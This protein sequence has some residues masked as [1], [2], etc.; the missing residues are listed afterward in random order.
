MY[1]YIYIYTKVIY[2]YIY[3][4]INKLV[5]LKTIILFKWP[6]YYDDKLLIRTRGIANMV[7]CNVYKLLFR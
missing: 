7:H 6:I 3:Y 1:I 4:T 5:V 2:I